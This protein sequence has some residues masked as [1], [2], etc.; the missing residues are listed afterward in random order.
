LASTAFGWNCKAASGGSIA[1]GIESVVLNSDDTS[2]YDQVGHASI[3]L[4]HNLIVSGTDCFTSGYINRVFGDYNVVIGENLTTYSDNNIALGKGITLGDSST[5]GDTNYKQVWAG[6]VGLGTYLK[7]TEGHNITIGYGRATNAQLLNNIPNSL[8]IGFRS[9]RPTFFVSENAESHSDGIGKV[10]IGTTARSNRLDV[11]GSVS[12]GFGTNPSTLSDTSSFAVKN[13]VGIG[14]V[15]PKEA[16]SVVNGQVIIWNIDTQAIANSAIDLAVRQK[17]VI[18]GTGVLLIDSSNSNNTGYLTT[19]VLLN[20]HGD[21]MKLEG[22]GT[23]RTASDARYKKDIEPFTDGLQKIK[24]IHPVT[25]RFN[26]RFGIGGKNKEIGVI[27]Q[28][29]QKILPYMVSEDSISRTVTA[30]AEKKYEVD[31]IDTQTIQVYDVTTKNEH[32]H[33][34]YKDSTIYK[35]AKKQIVEPAE[36]KEETL[37]LMSFNPNAFFYVLINSV[38]ELDSK[39]DLYRA[40]NDSLQLA[41]KKELD[42]KLNGNQTTIDSLKLIVK[43]LENR[44]SRLEAEK[45]IPLDGEQDVILEQN[46]PNPFADNTTITYFI[47]KKIQGIAELVITPISQ[48]VTLQKFSLIKG[49]PTQLVISARDLYTDVFIYSITIDGKVIASKKL[50]IIK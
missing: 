24:E 3:A 19:N 49:T 7:S 44:L 43:N 28:D 47:P 14:T 33:Y 17:V 26:G 11:N 31:V 39:I 27:A 35:L 8:M 12:V 30:N 37:P 42:N 34:L 48:S 40:S 18:G 46:N 38:K 45:Q 10:G 13:K 32:G 4:G 9:T 15:S 16:L 36:Y 6:S 5:T 50:I 23:W 29:I 25:F 41:Q 1:G 2:I 21:A 20:V 22:G